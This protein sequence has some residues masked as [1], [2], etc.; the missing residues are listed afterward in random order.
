[1]VQVA[2][3]QSTLENFSRLFDVGLQCGCGPGSEGKDSLGF[4]AA[5]FAVQ[6]PQVKSVCAATQVKILALQPLAEHPRPLAGR[7]SVVAC[8]KNFVPGQGETRVH[9]QGN[10][11]HR[12]ELRAG[13]PFEQ[14]PHPRLRVWRVK[15]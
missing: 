14:S 15:Q 3:G 2:A 5:F 10:C 1:M 11:S 13:R 8:V 6:T 4:Q 9:G 12:R 7:G